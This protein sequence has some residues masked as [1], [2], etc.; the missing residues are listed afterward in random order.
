M[1][2]LRSRRSGVVRFSRGRA[3]LSAA[4]AGLV[5]AW[6]GTMAACTHAPVIRPEPELRAEAAATLAQGHCPKPESGSLQ[7]VTES[8]AGPYFV[9]HPDSPS[10]D[11]PTVIF[12]PGGSGT[13]TIAKDFIWKNWLSRG[14]RL[15]EVR[16]IIPYFPN[17]EHMT[18][19]ESVR[20]LRI[21]EEALTCFGGK[22]ERVQLAGTSNGGRHAYFLMTAAPER[23]A[24]L[25]GS[26]GVF[27]VKI[28]DEALRAALRDKP[29]YNGVG[30]A[31]PDWKPPVQATQKRLEALGIRAAYVEFPEQGHIL[32]DKFDPSGFFDFWLD[33]PAAAAPA[34]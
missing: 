10:A 25:L 6:A 17:R 34:K 20:A 29:V 18:R 28:A 8:P 5:F 11:T 12:L 13:R 4:G 2:S 14:R 19:A 7:E 24:S 27:P 16:V 15:G 31:D 21:R 23:F 26:P 30:A 1:K 32:D 33:G 3:R 22:R 9:H